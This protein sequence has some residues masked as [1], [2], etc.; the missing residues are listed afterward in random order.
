MTHTKNNKLWTQTAQH[1]A[2]AQWML[3]MAQE[4]N[5]K[6]P[7][8]NL[9]WIPPEDRG[10]EDDRP[11]AIV[12]I[13]SDGYTIDVIKRLST[14]EFHP[15]FIFNWLYDHDSQRVD[16]WD[17]YMKQLKKEEKERQD[18]V[19]EHVF[20]IADQFQHVVKSPLHTYRINGHKVGAENEAPTIGLFD[21]T[22]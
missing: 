17:A 1:V 8:L 19:T 10:P 21:A 13:D 18:V 3:D 5:D 4:V 12:Q 7:N 16:V 9:S 22:D 20:K 14:F 15:S 6:Y 2:M 11:F